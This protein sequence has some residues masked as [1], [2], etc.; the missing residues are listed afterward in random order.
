LVGERGGIQIGRRTFEE[1]SPAVEEEA[2]GEAVACERCAARAPPPGRR[3]DQNAIVI[4]SA[5]RCAGP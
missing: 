5:E 1:K 4:A 2:H 3:A